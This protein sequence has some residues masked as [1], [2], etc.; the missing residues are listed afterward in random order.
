MERLSD[1]T[2][3]DWR[4]AAPIVFTAVLALADAWLLA[5]W[6][7]SV[8]G[9]AVTAGPI[10]GIVLSI[11]W[12]IRHFRPAVALGGLGFGVALTILLWRSVPGAAWPGVL[13]ALGTFGV[14]F[15]AYDVWF[16][17]RANAP[18]VSPMTTLGGR[19]SAGSALIVYHRGRG[20]LQFQARLQRAFAEGL[21]SQG[22]RVD[23]TT[24]SAQASADV[25][26]YDLLVL[27][28]QAYNWCPARPVVDYLRR[29]A[30][31]GGKPVVAIVSGGGMT[32]RA[33]RLLC[34][35]IVE[36]GGVVADMIEVWTTRSNEER[37]GLVD[38]DA[39]MR[40]AGARVGLAATPRAA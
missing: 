15:L 23:M 9:A 38:P 35:R 22:W 5:W 12:T 29:V 8:R 40:R 33:M 11:A 10:V 27:G 31:L 39:I 25:S 37:H 6:I 13:A 28:A 19:G 21:K 30:G 34:A 18:F 3:H 7:G 4:L 14:W 16:T 32:E 24:A 17:G 36:A 20:P 1:Y 26:R 2:P